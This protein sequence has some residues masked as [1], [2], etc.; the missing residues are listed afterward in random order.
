MHVFAGFQT[1]YCR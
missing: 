1:M